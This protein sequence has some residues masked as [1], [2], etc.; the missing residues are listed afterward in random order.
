MCMCIQDWGFEE[1]FRFLNEASS[2]PHTHRHTT[3]VVVRCGTRVEGCV[4]WKQGARLGHLW[5]TLRIDHHPSNKAR[6]HGH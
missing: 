3:F 1:V 2:V 6:G 4:S 5:E